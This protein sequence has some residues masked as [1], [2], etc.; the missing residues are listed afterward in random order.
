MEV[1]KL[2]EIIRRKN[3]HDIYLI[4]ILHLIFLATVG[5]K[6][7]EWD[8]PFLQQICGFLYLTFIPGYLIIRIINSNS[9]EITDSILLSIGL[10]ITTLMG[11]GTTLNYILPL[12]A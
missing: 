11:I 3:C 9:L 5:F 10:S 2:V 8:V 4:I 12:V 7:I 1:A 6:Y